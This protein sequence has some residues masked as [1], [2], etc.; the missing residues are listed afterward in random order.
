MIKCDA[1]LRALT[2]AGYI[3]KDGKSG[4]TFKYRVTTLGIEWIGGD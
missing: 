3:A 2:N 4:E 1:K